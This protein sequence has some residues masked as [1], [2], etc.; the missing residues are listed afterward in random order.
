MKHLVS[1]KEKDL[2][3][4]GNANEISCN[5]FY[6]EAYYSSLVLIQKKPKQLNAKPKI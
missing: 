6:T 3:I 1:K 4:R 5:F 2:K